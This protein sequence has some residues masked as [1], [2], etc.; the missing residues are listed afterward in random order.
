MIHFLIASGG[1]LKII[2]HHKVKIKNNIHQK[3][4]LYRLPSILI[5]CII[6][7]FLIWI[8]KLFHLWPVMASYE[9]IFMKVSFMAIKKGQIIFLSLPFTHIMNYFLKFCQMGILS[10]VSPVH[11]N[12]ACET[13]MRHFQSWVGCQINQW[14]VRNV[15]NW[16]ITDRKM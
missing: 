9:S 6:F 5:A 7:I 3:Q 4:Y 2:Y 12:I 16:P 11:F 8:S 14:E 1:L 13:V 15:D 10:N